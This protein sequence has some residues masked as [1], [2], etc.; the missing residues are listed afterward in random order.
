[1]QLGSEAVTLV[2]WMHTQLGVPLQKVAHLLP[3]R[4]SE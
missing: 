4:N 3:G 2:V 1:M